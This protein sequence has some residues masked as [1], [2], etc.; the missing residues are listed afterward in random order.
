MGYHNA[1]PG[2]SSGS[3]HGGSSDGGASRGQIPVRLKT[4]EA[5]P[6]V[7]LAEGTSDLTA[8][9]AADVLTVRLLPGG[10]AIY[11]VPG[12]TEFVDTLT[13]DQ[14]E[15]LGWA[16]LRETPPTDGPTRPI[17]VPQGA[18][19]GEFDRDRFEDV[20]TAPL[21]AGEICALPSIP[22][23][24][25]IRLESADASVPEI[26]DLPSEE[27]R[28]WVIGRDP[29]Q[30]DAV[31]DRDGHVSRR[32]AA[33]VLESAR[34]FIADLGSRWRTFVNGQELTRPRELHE[35]DVVRVGKTR[36]EFRQA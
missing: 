1:K 24:Q 6:L 26:L 8:V 27:G 19:D 12:A 5:V 31:L 4:A 22:K 16:L 10:T 18:P 21:S 32:H 23:A 13:A 15:Q 35:G 7:V 36:F 3:S 30:C 20:D 28:R 33:I 17:G 29:Q 2:P 9:R 11:R 34:Y 25:L 14:E